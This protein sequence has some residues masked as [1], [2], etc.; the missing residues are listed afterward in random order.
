MNLTARLAATLAS[1]LL[2]A[3]PVLAKPDK[4]LVERAATTLERGV[5]SGDFDTR[6][7]A[8]AGLGNL[9]KKRAMPLVTDAL[10]DPQWAV[11][12]AAI[13]ALRDLRDTRAWEAAVIEALRDLKIDVS[14]GSLP[15]LE[16]LGP[17]R[18]AALLAKALRTKDF[19][20]PERVA[21][22]LA[23][24]GGD[25]M[26]EGYR[27]ALRARGPFVEAFE[28]QLTRLPLPDA[29]PLWKD[30]LTQR[31][32]EVQREL[33]ARL[34]AH[35]GEPIDVAFIVPLLKSDDANIAFETARLLA[36]HDNR[37]GRAVLIAAAE[38]ADDARRLAAL[39]ALEPIATA[40][41]FDIVR[42]IVTD[43]SAD[44]DLLLAA[45]AI[46]HKGKNPKLAAYLDGQ[47]TN[48]D[49]NQRAAA[50]AYIGEVK[51]RAAIDDL[52]PLLGAGPLVIRVQ[53]ARSLGRLGQRAAIP[54]LQ[55]ALQSATDKEFKLA[56]LAALADVKDAE[57]IPVVRF[58][59]NDF[60]K[61]V[62]RAAVR[63][64]AAV[65]HETGVPD[66]E[67]ALQ[68]RDREI[69]VMAL[70]A[71]VKQDP[72]RNLRQFTSALQWIDPGFVTD[73]VKAWKGQA[74]PHLEAALASSRDDM[75]ATA[76]A[77]LRHLDKAD[78]EAITAALVRDGKR[79]ELRLASLDR[80][81]EL[82]GRGASPLLGE[83]ARGGHAGLKVAAL[84]HLGRIA[85]KD[86][87]DLL[88]AALDDPAERLRVIAAGALVGM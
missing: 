40:D 23:Q 5:K 37:A 35:A 12:A 58:Y 28:A 3:P 46:F 24:R 67:Q 87:L 30:G 73:L 36:R 45:Y 26:V 42:P 75:R 29:L 41:L 9:P 68:S 55:R 62:Q 2:L 56:L 80:Y 81:V 76:M 79:D 47:L 50:V 74:R 61:D 15:L 27:A 83:L 31:S 63:A 82:A 71:L 70:E 21:I 54:P 8:V 48:T 33:L 88:T 38:S 57:I 1:V 34:A 64:L 7:A 10:T 85:P 11:R 65:P 69:R 4:E 78:Q 66:L 77:A 84:E 14:L 86:H 59:L 32:P 49:I 13:G 19:P 52:V 6:A 39:R 20:K 17:K 22:A 53:A 44:L 16:P 72:E 60:D 43:R 51:G 25:W 18:G